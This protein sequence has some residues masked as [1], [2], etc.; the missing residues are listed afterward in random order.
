[1]NEDTKTLLWLGGGA[2][3]LWWLFK[4]DRSAVSVQDSTKQDLVISDLRG[5]HQKLIQE[6]ETIM[7]DLESAD[8]AEVDVLRQVLEDVEVKA[9]KIERQLEVLEA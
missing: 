8:D 1:M 4:D 7:E 2:L 3:F 6:A 9:A 5:E